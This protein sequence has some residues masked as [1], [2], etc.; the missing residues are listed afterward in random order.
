MCPFRVTCGPLCLESGDN[1][2]LLVLAVRFEAAVVRFVVEMGVSS[3]RLFAERGLSLI[4][5]T[6]AQH[7]QT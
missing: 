3:F 4:D 7:T 2:A 1:A 5:I 6:E